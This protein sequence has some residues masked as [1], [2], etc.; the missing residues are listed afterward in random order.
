MLYWNFYYKY[1][2]EMLVKLIVWLE[3]CLMIEGVVVWLFVGLIDWLI[4]KV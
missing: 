1:V 2:S 4:D 3:K